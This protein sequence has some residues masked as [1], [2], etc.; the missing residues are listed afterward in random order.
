MQKEG[1][2]ISLT[3][4]SCFHWARA[5]VCLAQQFLESGRL[6]DAINTLD[7]AIEEAHKELSI[8][9]GMKTWI[10]RSDGNVISGKC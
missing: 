8:T 10:N 4:T 7:Q 9:G 5:L 2:H 6:T 3:T 1:A